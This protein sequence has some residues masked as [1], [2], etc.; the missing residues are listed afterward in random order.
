M[1]CKFHPEILRGSPI[2][3]GVVKQ[4][5][6]IGKISSFLSLSVNVSK[7]VADT[8]KVT[9]NMRKSYG[10]SIDTKIDDLG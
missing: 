3:N 6:G 8:A 5:R 7:T 10:L 4:G 2:Q 9:I 1:R